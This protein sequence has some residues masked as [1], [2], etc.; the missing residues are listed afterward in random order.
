M[1]RPHDLGGEPAG[2]IDRRG[3]EIEDWERLTD[4]ITIALDRKGVKTT[5]EHRRAIESL[6]DYRK[7]S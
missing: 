2:P 1:E 3:H 7:L 5:D 6:P 4:A